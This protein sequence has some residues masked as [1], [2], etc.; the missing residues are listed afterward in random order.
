MRTRTNIALALLIIFSSA[1]VGYAVPQLINYQGILTD[2]GGTPITV[3]TTV[4]FRIWDADVGGA[5]LWMESQSVTPDGDGQFNVLLGSTS[6]LKWIPDSAFTGDAYL[7]MTVLPDPE[8]SPRMELVPVASAFRVRTVDGALGGNITTDVSIGSGHTVSGNNYLV[9]GR[10][11]TSS[12]SGSVV[13]GINNQASMATVTGGAGNNA[14]QFGFIG[15][16][17]GCT[18]IGQGAAIVAGAGNT[19]SGR[20]SFVGGGFKHH[21]AGDY[22]VVVGGG[23]GSSADSNLAM[24]EA[25]SILGGRGNVADGEAS[26]VVGGLSNTASGNYSTV[27]GGRYNTASG[28]S[29]YSTTVSGGSWNEATGDVSTV[30][31]GSNNKARGIY[32]VVAGGGGSADSNVA[33]SN[34]SSVL[35]GS[36]NIAEKPFSTVGGGAKNRARG[37]YSVVAGGGGAGTADTNSAS[38]DYS[39]ISG[40]RKHVAA[41]DYSVVAGGGGFRALEGNSALGEASAIPG[42][43]RNIAAGDFS[44]AAGL[45]AQANH[46]GCFVW[47][48]STDADFASTAADQFLIRAG[49]GVGIG[50]NDP[51]QTLHV[52]KGSAGVVDANVSSI[53]VFES[54]ATGYISILTPTESNSGLLFGNPDDVAD[55]S[56]LYNTT[57]APHGMLLRTNGNVTRMKIDSSGDICY[58]GALTACSDARYKT[59]VTTIPN[60]LDKVMQMRGVRYNWKQDEY[61]ERDFDD[62]QHLGFIAQEVEALFPEMVVTDGDGY[63][64]VD[65]GRLTP[66]LVEAIKDQQ[67]QINELRLL[68]EKQAAGR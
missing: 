27:A 17:S 7:G 67:R 55:G 11:N 48:D 63:K 10:D 8:M 18:T 33:M 19:A 3:P 57:T 59:D 30:G 1:T 14:G 58:Y 41:G 39:A 29:N 47:A 46:D 53:G 42:G 25:S 61:P 64:S 13:L 28:T 31:G 44:L 20:S 9:A 34:A 16:G 56:I 37:Y 12:G 51:D 54:D 52:F 35:G 24:G 2:G 23:S 32:S 36:G 38:G 22:S 43:R 66:V 65:Y 68:I 62:R 40:G 45:S 26:V 21:A 50:T 15:G 60:S 49:G 5:E 4:E 6:S